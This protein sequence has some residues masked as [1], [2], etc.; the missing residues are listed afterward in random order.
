MG[1]SIQHLKQKYMGFGHDTSKLYDQDA[2]I[3]IDSNGKAG[4][5][6]PLTNF[7]NAQCTLTLLLPPVTTG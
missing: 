4:H 3:A 2:Q 5:G 1:G 6:L 7:L